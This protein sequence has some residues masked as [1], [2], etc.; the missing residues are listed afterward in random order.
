M[1]CFNCFKTSTGQ[2]SNQHISESPPRDTPTEHRTSTALYNFQESPTSRTADFSTLLTPNGV[3][4]SILMSNQ[5]KTPMPSRIT[6]PKK[7]IIVNP[8]N[9]RSL[10]EQKQTRTPSTTT[11]SMQE[12]YE[13]L[14]TS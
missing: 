6:S 13:R 8:D 12:V 2:S 14:L 7:V 5:P 3:P 11:P 4:L 1:K 10:G 9:T